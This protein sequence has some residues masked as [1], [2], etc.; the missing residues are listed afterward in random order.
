MATRA[1]DGRRRGHPADV[2][3]GGAGRGLGGGTDH[4][5]RQARS[6]G[7]PRLG[8]KPRRPKEMRR[9]PGRSRRRGSAPRRPPGPGARRWRRPPRPPPAA[10]SRAEPLGQRVAGAASRWAAGRACRPCSARAKAASEALGAVLVLRLER[11]LVLGERGPQRD[12]RGRTHARELRRARAE[13]RV[14]AE[15]GQPRRARRRR[16]SGS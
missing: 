9:A 10:P 8:R 1:S 6:P 3:A 11:H 5:D 12:G 14:E 16:R 7:P 2:Q 4:R 13:P 15:H